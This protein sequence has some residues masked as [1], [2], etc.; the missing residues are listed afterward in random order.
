MAAQAAAAE[1]AMMAAHPRVGPAR[2]EVQP[3]QELMSPAI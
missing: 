2:V 3:V 1:P